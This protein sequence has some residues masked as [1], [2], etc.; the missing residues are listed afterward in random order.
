MWVILLELQ[1]FVVFAVGCQPDHIALGCRWRWKK[2]PKQRW[3]SYFSLCPFPSWRGCSLRTAR[4]G[5]GRAGVARR[6]KPLTA[7]TVLRSSCKR[8]RGGPKWT[9]KKAQSRTASDTLW[10]GLGIR[11]SKRFNAMRR[12]L[13]SGSLRPARKQRVRSTK[14]ASVGD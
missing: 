3:S 7:R 4:S 11:L 9:A 13:R 12:K 8:E 1:M 6:S 5:Q 2:G 14:F 10:H